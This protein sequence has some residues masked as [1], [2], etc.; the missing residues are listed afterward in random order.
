MKKNIIWVSIILASIILWQALPACAADFPTKPISLIVG[1]GPGGMTDVCSRLFAEK[2]EKFLGQKVIVENKP[3]AGGYTA[4]I[5][6]LNGSADGYTFVSCS[7]STASATSLLG[8]PLASEKLGL[9]G[10]FMPQERVLFARKDVPFRTFEALV[11]YAKETPVTFAGGGSIWAARVVEAM[12]KE[13]DLKIRIVPFRS[14]AEGSAAIIGGHVTLAETGVGTGAWQ[15]ALKGGLNIIAVLTDGDLKEFG[16]PEVKSI[17]D[18]GV[19]HFARIYFGYA[20]PAGVPEERRQKLEDAL[21][22]AVEDPEV[23]SKMKELDLKPRFL[24]AKA[25]RPII[26]AVFKEAAE[27]AN[28]LKE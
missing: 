26:E 23:I 22:F 20:L 9:I 27:L 28:Y 8:R 25:Y 12:A 3:G 24:P 10:S 1:F 18:Y 17:K 4:L 6:V 2:M 11:E 16:F 19:T 21:K 14:G 13:L 7:T 15:S 5:S